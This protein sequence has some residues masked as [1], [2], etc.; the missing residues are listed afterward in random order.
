MNT[1]QLYQNIFHSEEI[2]M[3]KKK[4]YSYKIYHESYHIFFLNYSENARNKTP[5]EKLYIDKKMKNNC[6]KLKNQ[7]KRMH[8]IKKASKN[9]DTPHISQ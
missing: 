7:P 9:N 4:K 6:W 2:R 1:S 3:K 5:T 8:N